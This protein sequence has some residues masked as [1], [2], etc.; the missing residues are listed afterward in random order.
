MNSKLPGGFEPTAPTSYALSDCWGQ[1]T[2]GAGA[3]LGLNKREPKTV[4]QPQNGERWD[5]SGEESQELL[6]SRY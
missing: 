5:F 4:D 1:A 6:L 2:Q 3:R